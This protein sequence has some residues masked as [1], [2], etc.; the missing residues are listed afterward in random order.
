VVIPCFNDG[1]TIE[2]ALASLRDQERCEVVIVNDGS[3][4]AATLEVLARV[5]AA[6]TRVIHQENRG[7][8]AARVRGVIETEAPYIQ[9]LDADD[10]LPPGSLAPLADALDADPALGMVW[11]D[12]QT[13]GEVEFRQRRAEDLDPWAITHV[14]Q[15]TE[16]LIRREALFD[17]G[18]WELAVG[19]EDWDLYMGLAEKGWKGRRL[20]LV[21]YL[22]RISSSR[23]LSG[24]RS[25]HDRLYAQMRARHRR[26][27][28]ARPG[29]WRRS[30]AP[31]TMRL[32]V[33]LI[34]RLPVSGLTRHRLSLVATEP[35]HAVRVRLARWTPGGPRR[36]R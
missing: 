29:N 13:F 25:H 12:H 1:A 27:F 32:A 5:E 26:L 6:G 21:T 31:L 19:Y 28:A 30:T 15:L 20:D 33:P 36:G 7:L 10:M 22:Y 14:N 8:S 3:D 11:G 2:A 34:A 9:P 16:G 18:G 35:R 4:S 17:A 24:A 23:M